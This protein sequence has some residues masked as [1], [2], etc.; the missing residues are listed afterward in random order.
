MIPNTIKWCRDFG[1]FWRNYSKDLIKFD[2]NVKRVNH[3][4]WFLMPTLFEIQWKKMWWMSNS[5]LCLLKTDK[6][7]KIIYFTYTGVTWNNQWTTWKTE[8][9]S[10]VNL[11]EVLRYCCCVRFVFRVVDWTG[12]LFKRKWNIW[13]VCIHSH[14]TQF[15]VW[16]IVDDL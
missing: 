1:Q 11:M 8:W 7:R 5:S 14:L 4:R 12:L 6:I 3:Q 13:S 10:H 16:F 15:P 2:W 9:T